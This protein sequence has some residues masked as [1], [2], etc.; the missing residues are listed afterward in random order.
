MSPLTLFFSCFV[1]LLVSVSASFQKGSL[2]VLKDLNTESWNGRVGM[3]ME[4]VYEK[5]EGRLPILIFI[6]EKMD[7]EEKAIKKINLSSPRYVL[8]KEKNLARVLED[9]IQ[10]GI[11][12]GTIP[13]KVPG[14]VTTI[15]TILIE[16]VFEICENDLHAFI[17]AGPKAMKT[18]IIGAYMYL[19]YGHDATIFAMNVNDAYT[20]HLE[21]AF[22]GIGRIMC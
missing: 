17:R 15:C 9:F 13:E 22:D 4:D 16:K 18:R 7:F 8:P 11:L 20:R 14:E 5:D 10:T 3:V 12:S 21:H 6:E 1:F 2:V 19:K